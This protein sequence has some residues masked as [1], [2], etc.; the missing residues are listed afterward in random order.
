MVALTQEGLCLFGVVPEILVL[1]EGVQLVAAAQG[2]VPVKDT[3]SAAFAT[4]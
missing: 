1:G 3:S 2:V 4:A